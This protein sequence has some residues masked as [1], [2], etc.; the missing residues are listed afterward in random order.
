MLDISCCS[1]PN[2][3]TAFAVSY[4]IPGERVTALD[5]GRAFEH[6]CSPELERCFC[7]EDFARAG[8]FSGDVL[9][10]AID[11]LRDLWSE[12]NDV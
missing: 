12:E 1:A 10:H 5:T 2:E 9:L 4:A 3:A 7:F 6:H 11:V 8:V